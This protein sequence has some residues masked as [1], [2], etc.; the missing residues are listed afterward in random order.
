MIDSKK[1]S[2]STIAFEANV[3]LQLAN[4]V[5]SK[6]N[7]RSGDWFDAKSVAYISVDHQGSTIAYSLVGQSYGTISG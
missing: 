3:N 6:I 1:G 7:P 4:T 5:R 2:V